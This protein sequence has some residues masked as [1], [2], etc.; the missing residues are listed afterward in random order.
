MEYSTQIPYSFPIASILPLYNTDITKNKTRTHRSKSF[1]ED[2][3]EV[4]TML[5][6]TAAIIMTALLIG[7]MAACSSKSD[8]KD[9]A[10]SAA[11]QSVIVESESEN[12]TI[13]ADD[14]F[15][16]KED[17]AQS[18]TEDNQSSDDSASNAANDQSE[19]S[20]AVSGQSGVSSATSNGFK[21]RSKMTDE[22]NTASPDTSVSNDFTPA[23]RPDNTEAPE[24]MTPPDNNSFSTG[25]SGS[26]GDSA[27]SAS[28]AIDTSDIFSDRDL[29]QTA[30]L[31]DSTA[32][33]AE[34]NKT[35]T[36]SEA[37]VY[38][39]TGSASNFTIKVETDKESKVQLVLDGVSI[40]NDDFPVIYVVSADKVF[41]TTTD[42]ENTL[43]VTGTFTSDGDT[44]TDAVIF[45]KDDL[46]LNG[47][48]T[49]VI[50]SSGNGISGKDDIKI[51]GGSYKLTTVKDSIE[52]NDS[53]SVYD[54][55]FEI[56]SSKDAFHSEND[57]DDTVGWIYIKGGTF[58]I[59][60][61]SDSIQATTIAQIDGGTFE[62]VSSEGIEATYVI[63]NGGD[64]SIT[65]SDDGINASRKSNSVGT[66]TIEFNGGTTTIVMGQGDTDAVDANGNIIV[67]GGTINVTAQMS[68]F[69]YD[70]TA[71]YNGGTII[72]NGSQVDSIP[73]SMMGGGMGGM[74]GGMRGGWG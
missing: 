49:L 56:N 57:D 15:G 53:I 61:S 14:V 7:S 50:S 42:T 52:A 21:K 13:S 70:G 65:A 33:S 44:N 47:T 3:K 60:A 40:T 62:L 51:T 19:S 12:T 68:S 43:S 36:I 46:V 69:D 23:Q 16:S 25:N 74:R 30:D 17:S 2:T 38:V 39:I 10:P 18:S 31:S 35:V 66:P 24:N 41:V 64:I 6:R 5:K 63:I 37:G 20:E 22:Q 26:T 9:T 54:G 27:V 34:N 29:A 28:A 32:I 45:S 4:I 72:I 73:Q 11:V 58:N 71:Q 55:T 67:N 48:G 1:G 59:K 8:S